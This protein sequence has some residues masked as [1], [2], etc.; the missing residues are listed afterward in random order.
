MSDSTLG[1]AEERKVK[2]SASNTSK[3]RCSNRSSRSRALTIDCHIDNLGHFAND[4]VAVTVEWTIVRTV[5]E[6]NLES[7]NLRFVALFAGT[8]AIGGLSTIQDAG[9]VTNGRR[10]V[11][12]VLDRL[13]CDV[14]FGLQF[15]CVPR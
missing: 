4:I 12:I 15:G 14:E 9:S 1:A 6:E 3:F 5:C 11:G 10:G 13:E 2:L 8:C 7:F